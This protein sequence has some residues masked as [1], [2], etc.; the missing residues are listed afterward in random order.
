MSVMMLALLAL[1][2]QEGTTTV[3]FNVKPMA[4]PRPALRYQFLPTLA[5][6][7]TGLV[8][9]QYMKCFM[10]QHNF[11]HSKESV[12]NR[13]KWQT[14]PLADLPLK[15]VRN[16]GGQALRNAD[17]AARMSHLDWQIMRDMKRHG[18]Y[19]LLPELQHLRHL[20]TALKVRL[21]GEVAEKRFDDAVGTIKTLFKL[22]HQM[23]EHPTL[24][25]NLVGTSIVGMTLPCVEE[26]IQQEGCPNLYWALASLPS[27]LVSLRSGMQGERTFLLTEQAT[28]PRDRAAT[29]KQVEATISMLEKLYKDSHLTEGLSCGA[30][31]PEFVYDGPKA[32]EEFALRKL[33]RE[34][35]AKAAEVKAARGRL[36]ES[37]LKEAAVKEMLATQVILVDAMLDYEAR[38]DARA[39]WMVFPYWK[40]TPRI[41]AEMK[42]KG[43][44][45]GWLLPNSQKVH[46]AQARTQQR[47]GM[48]QIL[49][50]LRLHAA[51]NKGK[52]PTKLDEVDL[53]LP[54][55]PFTGK[56]FRYEVKDGTAILRGTP[57]K[58]MEKQA[59]YNIVYELKLKK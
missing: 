48:L 55:D 43:G 38:L 27:P 30:D 28:V 4:E 29:P 12:A 51:A 35:A 11:Y 39:R 1:P 21:R 14:C 58:G 32:R 53:P 7:E 49:E 9:Q 36:V 25:G 41:E 2:A 24:I 47:L 50:A 13:E 44:A 6:I 37:G 46:Q 40:S 20:G 56:P 57:P 31:A 45:L 16:Y 33:V 15:E 8:L 54:V 23:G 19:T 59:A 17:R 34:N 22:G 3:R 10:E 26:M 5:E 18:A 42:R 52:L